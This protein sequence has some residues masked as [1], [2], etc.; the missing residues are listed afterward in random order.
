MP[1]LPLLQ[2]L[3][4]AMDIWD[5]VDRWQQYLL[6]ALCLKSAQIF[7]QVRKDGQTFANES[8]TD[9]SLDKASEWVFKLDLED[10]AT[11]QATSSLYVANC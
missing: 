1:S 4:R 2:Q 7:T 11:S 3:T 10:L 5:I 6:E 8:P 9:P